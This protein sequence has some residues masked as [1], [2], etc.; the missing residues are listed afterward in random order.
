MN[1]ALRH[2]LLVMLFLLAQAGAQLHGYTHAH[3][4]L[5]GA[6][7]AACEQC[8]AYAPMGAA[9]ASSPPNL[10]VFSMPPGRL[11]AV[12][13]AAIRARFQSGYRSRAP[14]PLIG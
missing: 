6:G 12:I 7:G 4:Q 5:S 14:P 9:A 3:D 11:E 10:H 2:L 8:L 13:P 1:L